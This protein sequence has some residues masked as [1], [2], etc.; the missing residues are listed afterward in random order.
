MAIIIVYSELV[1]LS[2]ECCCEFEIREREVFG[3]AAALE[4]ARELRELGRSFHF[5]R[6]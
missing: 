6:A 3:F 5:R 4:F 1:H 2:C